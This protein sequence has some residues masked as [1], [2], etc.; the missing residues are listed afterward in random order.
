MKRTMKRVKFIIV[1]FAGVF[2]IF[3]CQKPIIT[4]AN[5]Q[6]QINICSNLLQQGYAN[7][8][9]LQKEWQLKEFA[10]TSDGISINTVMLEDRATFLI[11]TTKIIVKIIKGNTLYFDYTLDSNNTLHIAGGGGTYLNPAPSEAQLEIY[12]KNVLWN[13]YC[14]SIQDTLLIIHH[15]DTLGKNLLILKEL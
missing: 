6:T 11:D 9:S 8:D 12:L 4:E 10:Y 14:Y 15:Q 2:G 7:G 1:F 5:S 13:A 3:N